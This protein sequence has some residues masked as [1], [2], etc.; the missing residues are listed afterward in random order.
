VNDLCLTCHDGQTFA[1]DVLANK[2]GSAIRQAGALNRD[3]VAPYL[4][5]HGHTL[6]TFDMA[7][8]GQPHGYGGPTPN[9]YRNL[10][11]FSGGGFHP[12][13]TYAVGT[14]DPNADVFERLA[15]GANHYDISNIDFNEP[16]PTN[17]GYATWCKTCHTDFHGAKGG[18]EVGG[19]SGEEWVRHPQADADIGFIGGG[20]SSAEVFADSLKTNWVK[21]MT[22]TGNWTPSDPVDVTDHTPSCFTCHKGHG[23]QNTF[24]LI[25]M[26]ATGTV[27]EEGTASGQYVDLC[28]QCHVQGG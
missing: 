26:E 22:A 19:A 18:P 27:T 4:D 11:P 28:H 14:N 1:P 20:H 25:F 17:S 13:V 5:T 8:G 21:V 9:P 24:G 7:P 12:S 16:D 15:G 23:N 2:T 10:S 3:N 6:G